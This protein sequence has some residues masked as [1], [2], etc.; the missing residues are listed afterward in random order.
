MRSL[1]SLLVIIAA[2]AVT[3]AP[4]HAQLFAAVA[5]A[6]EPAAA[7]AQDTVG[8]P[9]PA[10]EPDQLG[11]ISPRGTMR[12]YIDAMAQEDYAKAGQFFDLSALSKSDRTKRALTLPVIF[13]SMLDDN[14]S[15][16]PTA[17]LSDLP[18]GVSDDNLPEEQERIG[19]FTVDD[20][21]VPILLEHKKLDD[22]T[23]VWL[24]SADTVRQIP[25]EYTDANDYSVNKILPQALLEHKWA[26]VAAGHW[27]AMGLLIIAAYLACWGASSA[28]FYAAE[29][30][31]RR[32]RAD[33]P[34]GVFK[35]FSLPVRL[36][37][38]V[39]LI[40]FSAH[41]VGISV[42]VR[43]Y[44]SKANIIV[45]GVAVLIL[46]WQLIDVFSSIMQRRMM[47]NGQLGALSTV[48]F[49][50]RGVKFI[51]IALGAITVLDTLGFNVTAGLTALGIG[52][53]AL[54]LGAQKTV[55]NLVGSLTVIFDQPVRVG[56]FCKVGDTTGTIEQIGMRSTRIRTL[57]RTLVTIPNGDFAAQRIENYAHRDRFKFQTTLG[58]RYETS[59][60]QI[61]Y[62]LMELRS[63]LFAHS[64]VTRDP[65]RVR[66]LGFGADSLKIEIFTYI[67]STDH[68][69]FLEIQ[70]D[71]NL[72][73]ADIL[74]DSGTS[75]AFT[76]QTLYLARDT[77]MSREKKEAA[78]KKVADWREKTG[79]KNPSYDDDYIRSIENTI[80]FP[81]KTGG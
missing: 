15:L 54:A 77:G 78:E 16:R 51:L 48:M 52:G 13:Q 23:L 35:A 6:A 22:G 4:A 2:L 44:V 36:Y 50:R 19:S 76:S 46:L 57:D 45:A 59:P 58:V 70:E 64:R 14:G 17:L 33:T 10:P 67:L 32:R 66:F 3:P 63:M 71:L 26:G 47:R 34:Q 73:I 62:L 68:G 20:K 80:A 7:P 81:Q 53:I 60:D 27:V 69:E 31:W 8:P 41:A 56:D 9:A 12:G 38:T 49:F 65:A 37:A 42:I 79:L 5:K 28:F 43:Q 40:I 55:E 25:K 1:L 24:I 30:L 29:S 21:S 72:R 18:Q 74:E 75:L 61:R 39:W 11:R